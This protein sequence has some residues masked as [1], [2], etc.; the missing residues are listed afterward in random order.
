MAEHYFT[1]EP[2]SEKRIFKHKTI[3]RNRE[4]E[5][6]TASGLFS[7]KQVDIG[8]ALLIN[9]SIIKEGW[10]ILDLGCGCGIVG[11]TLKIIFPSLELTFSDIN[12]RALELTEKNLDF[13]KIKGETVQSDGFEKIK[14]TF[15]S[16]LLNPPQT[17]GKEICF[18]LIED[19]KAHLNM[20]G[21]FQLVAR[22]K[23]GGRV[24]SK[25][26]LEVF[27]NVKDTAKKAGYRIYV[28]EKNN[29]PDE[30][31]NTREKNDLF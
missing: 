29:I 6:F 16:I 1:K 22:H 23:K 11:L 5:F 28:S 15:D 14:N 7:I 3:L 17:A 8:S 10:K 26:M 21:L 27:G 2:Q 20:R 19:A 4:I 31:T 18:K 12:E 30:E 25:K 9:K 24:L 13:H